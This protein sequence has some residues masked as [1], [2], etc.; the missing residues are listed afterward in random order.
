MESSHTRPSPP[1][2]HQHPLA[3][4]AGAAAAAGDALRRRA[5]SLAGRGPSDPQAQAPPGGLGAW[6]GDQGRATAGPR[7]HARDAGVAVDWVADRRAAGSSGSGGGSGGSSG[8]RHP[9]TA[10]DAAKADLGRATWTL[11]HTLAAQ[12]PDR[13]S[14]RQREDVAKLVRVGG[15]GRGRG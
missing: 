10:H 13:P 4:L 7:R 9:P 12:Y 2:A 6:P 5:A 15:E 8:A 11:L 1:H 14:R 3:A